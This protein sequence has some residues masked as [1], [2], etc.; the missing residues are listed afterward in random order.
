MY[1]CGCYYFWL[2]LL[3]LVL[4]HHYISL[5]SFLS[6]KYPFGYSVQVNN[7]W[8]SDIRTHTYTNAS[9]KRNQGTCII[10]NNTHLLFHV[11]TCSSSTLLEWNAPILLLL[12][13]HILATVW[14]YISYW[15]WTVRQRNKTRISAIFAENTNLS[16]SQFKKT[17]PTETKRRTAMHLLTLNSWC[18][19]YK[20]SFNSH[21]MHNHIMYCTILRKISCVTV[22]GM[23][24]SNEKNTASIRRFHFKT[25]EE[26]HSNSINAHRRNTI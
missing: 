16:I 18:V 11:H 23:N 9:V 10:I 6:V 15:F 21:Q 26:C 14:T 24:R 13:T 25:H 17:F 2:W 1:W 4:F 8:H 12:C 20:L 7:T 3:F 19:K 22:N 5:T